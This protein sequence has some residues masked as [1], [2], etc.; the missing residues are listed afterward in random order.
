MRVRESR[1][2]CASAQRS[3]VCLT[4]TLVI[5]HLVAGR[6]DAPEGPI[7]VLT[8]SRR[9]GTREA[10]ALVDICVT[11]D[12]LETVFSTCAYVQNLFC[13]F[14]FR[15]TDAV[16]LVHGVLVTLV[17][18]A[19]EEAQSVDTLSVPA[20]LA[21][22]SAALVDVCKAKPAA[23]SN[24]SGL[25]PPSGAGV[26]PSHPCSRC[27]ASG[28]SRG[29]RGS[30]RSPPC[31]YRCRCRTAACRTRRYLKWARKQGEKRRWRGTR[32]P[33]LRVSWESGRGAHPCTCSDR[34][35]P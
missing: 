2:V 24:L 6:A 8:G 9:A 16:L 21:L 12:Q 31:F 1:P 18:E 34:P 11:R 14:R 29:S 19:L 30:C 15:P 5:L 23:V 35:W 22:E 13:S 20:H 7:Q 32:A 10:H 3:D 26:R 27:C 33:T 17:A 28:Q 4:D 25:G